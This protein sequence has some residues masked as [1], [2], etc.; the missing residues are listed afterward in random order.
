[1]IIQ[2]LL[3][4]ERNLNAS[5]SRKPFKT[6]AYMRFAPPVPHNFGANK[7]DPSDDEAGV[8]DEESTSSDHVKANSLLFLDEKAEGI[9][10]KELE[11]MRTAIHRKIQDLQLGKITRNEYSKQAKDMFLGGN[12]VN[13]SGNISVGGDRIQI[14][15]LASNMKRWSKEFFSVLSYDWPH[16][17]FKI[18]LNSLVTKDKVDATTTEVEK[19]EEDNVPAS[20]TN[21]IKILEP[22]STKRFSPGAIASTEGADELLIQFETESQ[23][24]PPFGVLN[25]YMNHLATHGKGSELGLRRR[26]DRC[27]YVYIYICMYIRICI[28]IHIYK[29]IYINIYIYKY[30]YINKY[31]YI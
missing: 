27:V 28:Y 9:K 5:F 11:N 1:M 30:I 12:F 31:I 10:A 22:V 15:K 26:C 8:G 14:R 7:K 29:H 25:K 19:S 18:M 17:R 16:L 20:A 23:A 2:A 21:D 13:Q 24:L 6:S 3:E 4:E